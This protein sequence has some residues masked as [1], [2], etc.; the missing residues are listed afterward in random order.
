MTT[1]KKKQKNHH[2][3]QKVHPKAVILQRQIQPKKMT[4]ALP[5]IKMIKKIQQKKLTLMIISTAICLLLLFG[6][7]LIPTAIT[8]F[9]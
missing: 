6:R 4:K 5:R 2:L 8:F 7:F 3:H 1:K 9:I